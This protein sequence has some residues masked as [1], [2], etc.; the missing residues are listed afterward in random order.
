MNHATR[1]AEIARR[2]ERL[3]AA[4]ARERA[5]LGEA[6]AAWQVPIAAV[7]R[8]ISATRFLAAHPV[9]VAA[10]LVIVAVLGR[11]GLLRWAGRGLVVWRAWRT[12][13]ALV[14]TLAR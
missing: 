5:G 7:D 4:C 2:K 11:R 12:V 10:G 14:G 3:V 13:R 6:L 1:M 8:G 9:A